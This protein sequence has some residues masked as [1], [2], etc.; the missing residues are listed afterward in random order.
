MK[1][2]QSTHT[3][4]IDYQIN[5]CIIIRADE[6]NTINPHHGIISYI[7]NSVTINRKKIIINTKKERK[8]K[9]PITMYPPPLPIP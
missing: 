4:S 3:K 6:K 8:K 5:N 1:K 9:H 7:H 2:I